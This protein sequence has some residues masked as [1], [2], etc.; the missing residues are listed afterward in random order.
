MDSNPVKIANETT[1]LQRQPNDVKNQTYVSKWPSNMRN[2]QTAYQAINEKKNL[3][4]F[5]VQYYGIK[6]QISTTELQAP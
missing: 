3:V 5:Y 6:Q 2:A 4:L 1:S